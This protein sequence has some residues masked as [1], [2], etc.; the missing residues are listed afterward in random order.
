M[1]RAAIGAMFAVSQSAGRRGAIVEAHPRRNEPM[2]H[3]PF[4][5]FAC[6]QIGASRTLRALDGRPSLFSRHQ[7]P[8]ANCPASSQRDKC[9][10]I[11]VELTGAC[12]GISITSDKVRSRRREGTNRNFGTRRAYRSC[13]RFGHL[14]L[15]AGASTRKQS[16]EKDEANKPGVSPFARCECTADIALA[17]GLRRRRG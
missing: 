7:C 11:D 15:H 14:F 5:S 12:A 13:S 2:L 10:R 1:A 8:I 3:A 16:H 6:S 9:G 4:S 17:G